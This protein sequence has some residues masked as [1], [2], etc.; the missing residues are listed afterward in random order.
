MLITFLFGVTKPCQRFFYV[1]KYITMNNYFERSEMLFGKR[2][3]E[4][5][6][7]SHVAV[8]GLGGVGSY[9][10]ESLCRG[11]VGKLSL[12]DNDI[13]TPSNVNRQLYA[14]SLTL[15]RKKVDVAKER[16]L[17]INPQIKVDVYDKFILSGDSFGI[18]FS[19]F[20][21]V[22]DAID[23]ISGKLEIVKMAN[24]FNVPVISCMSAGN[25]LDQTAFKVADIKNTKVCPLCRVMRKLL[26]ENGIDSLKVVYSEEALAISSDGDK[27]KRIPYSNS[28][29]PP[30]VGLIA[31]G[32]VIKDLTKV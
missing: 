18:D 20:D 14:T 26:K 29:V 27:D 22:V 8:F 25:K 1:L 5:L 13:Y 31:S 17:S 11:G 15:G 12:I 19:K 2:A 28:F 7:N 10:V 6:Y 30:I 24:K 4:K 3:M 16:V 32:E 21:Y 23:T 9:A